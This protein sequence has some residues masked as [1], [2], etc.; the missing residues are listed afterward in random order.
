MKNNIK[1]IKSNCG[2]YIFYL[3][4]QGRWCTKV[5]TGYNVETGQ[6]EIKALY[7][8]TRDEVK[9]KVTNF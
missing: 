8:K 5:Q 4:S 3:K 9:L 2:L 6:S 1:E 7:G